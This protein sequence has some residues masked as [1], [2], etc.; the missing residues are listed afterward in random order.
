MVKASLHLAMMQMFSSV[1]PWWPALMGS[2][3][4]E[5]TGVVAWTT[6]GIAAAVVAVTDPYNTQAIA[7]CSQMPPAVTTSPHVSVPF[8]SCHSPPR[9]WKWL[10]EVDLHITQ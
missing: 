1:R 6:I 2:S 7:V 9:R 4:V 8:P 10:L 5:A 3:R